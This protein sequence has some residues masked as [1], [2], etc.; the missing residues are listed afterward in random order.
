MILAL[1]YW[2]SCTLSQCS[3]LLT[4]DY[5]EMERKQFCVQGEYTKKHQKEP[6]KKKKKDLYY[7]KIYVLLIQTLTI[8]FRDRVYFHYYSCLEN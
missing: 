2:L 1:F 8:Y 6:Q 7:I 3:I 4:F 5:L